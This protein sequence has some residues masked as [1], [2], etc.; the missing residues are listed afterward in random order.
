MANRS[1]FY[2]EGGQQRGPFPDAQFRDLIAKGMV[3]ADTL[4]WTDGMAGLAKGRRHSRSGFSRR[5]TAGD[6]RQNAA[7]R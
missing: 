7:G 3:R 1:W 5:Q 4:I 6:A 2:A